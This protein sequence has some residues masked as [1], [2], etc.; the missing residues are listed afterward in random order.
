MIILATAIILSLN[1][2][3]II[4]SAEEAR[5]KSSIKA[6][7]QELDIYIANRQLEELGVFDISKFN[8]LPK[9]GFDADA[10]MIK[11]IPG[12]NKEDAKN[13][14]IIAGKLTYAGFDLDKIEWSKDIGIEVQMLVLNEKGE[15]IG[16]EGLKDLYGTIT[17]PDY[18]TVINQ[19]AFYGNQGIEHVV[20]SEDSEV[21]EIPNYAFQNCTNLKSIILPKNLKKIGSYAFQNCIR[22]SVIDIPNTVE[23]IGISAFYLCYNLSTIKLP[24]NEGFTTIETSSFHSTNL[25]EIQIP[26]NI[27][28]IKG[29]AFSSTKLD[30]VKIPSSVTLLENAF[31]TCKQLQEINVEVG[32][33]NYASYQGTL[34]TKDFKIL[35]TCPA[36]KENVQIKEETT[37]ITVSAFGGCEKLITLNIPQNVTSAF[38]IGLGRCISLESLIVDSRNP[39]YISIDNNLYEKNANGDP[40]SIAGISNINKNVV[41]P[42]TVERIN[43]LSVN[44]VIGLES[45]DMSNTK[46]RIIPEQSISFCD[47]LSTIKL[48]NTLES[49]DNIA[50]YGSS[51][52]ELTIPASVTTISGNALGNCKQ[53]EKINLDANN[54]NFTVKG[55]AI[56]TRDMK[57]LVALSAI[58]EEYIIPE[59]VITINKGAIRYC[60]KLKK[61]TLPSTLVQIENNAM[62]ACTSLKTITIPENVTDIGSLAFNGCSQL[63]E[64]K[65]KM[66]ED[67]ITGAPWGAPYGILTVKWEP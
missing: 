45:L 43:S 52:K 58:Y 1:G 48:P 11:I 18:I 39:K 55:T 20:F 13:Y 37:N 67:K 38:N 19:N 53:L 33:L 23:T 66:E 61:L 36:G 25:S 41:V 64:I 47:A 17:I 29:G 4:Q 34:Y 57:N 7:K 32:N 2:T 31:A 26:S 44:G 62:A 22:L 63:K 60:T 50:F 10:E 56:Y 3:G 59:G 49:I 14:Q 5:F 42:S 30:I 8:V 27:K 51:I 65:L 24:E 54:Q 15:L 12:M 35:I 6:Y 28:T 40:I 9:E 46:I 21:I 16:V